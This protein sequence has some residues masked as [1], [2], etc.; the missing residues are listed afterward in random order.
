MAGRK[1][2][3]IVNKY[4]P[5]DLKWYVYLIFI[6]IEIENAILLDATVFDILYFTTY[7]TATRTIIILTSVFPSTCVTGILT[8]LRS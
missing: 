2:H 5:W 8:K 7:V 6:N 4:H 3:K 1:V